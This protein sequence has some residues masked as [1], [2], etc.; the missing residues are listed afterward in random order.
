M[1]AVISCSTL[2]AQ[3]RHELTGNAYCSGGAGS[4]PGLL[5]CPMPVRS[6]VDCFDCQVTSTCHGLS[7]LLPVTLQLDACTGNNRWFAKVRTVLLGSETPYSMA[8]A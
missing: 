3:D 8:N 5:A 2:H 7:K 1:A 6:V 4:R